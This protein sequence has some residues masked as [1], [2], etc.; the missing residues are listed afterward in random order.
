MNNNVEVTLKNTSDLSYTAPGKD[1][2]FAGWATSM[3]DA[4]KGNA[5]YAVGEKVRVNADSSND[6]Y[7]TWVKKTV[8]EVTAIHFHIM[9]KYRRLK[10]LKTLLLD[11]K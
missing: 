10:A 11:M 5:K 2:Y 9:V 7:A 3:E 8:I 1:Y 6:L 4:Q